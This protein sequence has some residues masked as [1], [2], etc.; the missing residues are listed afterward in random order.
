M[1]TLS[2]SATKELIE[3]SHVQ[4]HA[5]LQK[6]APSR[7]HSWDWAS[8]EFADGAAWIRRHPHE[9]RTGIYLSDTPNKEVWRITI[10]DVHG[11]GEVVF[12]FYKEP[13]LS[14]FTIGKRSIAVNEALNY[15]TL[16]GLGIPVAKTLYIESVAV[17]GK[18]ELQL[19]GQ[20]GDVMKESIRIARTVLEANAKIF[21]IPDKFFKEND[22][23]VHVPAGATPKDGPS[24][25][26]TMAVSMLS[27]ATNRTLPRNW[28]M[29][30][31]LTLKGRVLPVGGIKEK[32]IAAKRA[33]VLDIIMPK[34][35]EKDFAEIPDRVRKDLTVHYVEQIDE[36]FAL[37]FG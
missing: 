24:A 27:L 34:A 7:F 4:Y 5:L 25:G 14:L 6:M 35:N 18:G 22:I 20:L 15:A 21:K 2:A 32:T 31:E 11:G 26:I 10:P 3:S 17:P 23:H 30:G 37:L 36:V 33:G 13:I 28:A 1:D 19:T 16:E 9:V 12:K 29:T 8:D